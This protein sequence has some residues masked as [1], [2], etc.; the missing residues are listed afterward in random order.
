MIPQHR[1]GNPPTAKQLDYLLI[2]FNDCGFEDINS[3]NAWLTHRFQRLIKH[4][5]ELTSREASEVITILKQI[6]EDKK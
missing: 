5:D 3:R 4:C 2:L 1:M 6:R